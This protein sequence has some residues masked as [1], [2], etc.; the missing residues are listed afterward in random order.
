[1][2]THWLS[3][4][5]LGALSPGHTLALLAVLV[6]ANGCT[7]KNDNASPAAGAS[8]GGAS[9]AGSTAMGGASGGT[10][11]SGGTT[12]GT[13]TAG[14][15][16]AGGSTSTAGNQGSGGSSVSG[17]L[18]GGFVVGL[19]PAA[20]GAPAYTSV[21]GRFYDGPT[22]ATI[23]LKEAR[24]QGN[25]KLLVPFVPFCEPM[26]DTSSA[27]CTADNV[28]TPKPKPIAVG[29]VQLSGLGS[30]PLTLKPGGASAYQPSSS[31]PNPP[32]QPGAEVNLAWNG[33][34]M[35]TTCI[36]ALEVTTPSPIP[37]KT[38]SSVKLAWTPPATNANTRVRIAMDLAHHG[39]KKG[40]IQCEVDDTGSFEIPEP[41]ITDLVQLGLAGFPTISLDRVSVGKVEALPNVTL[42]MSSVVTLPVDTGVVSCVSDT[43]CNGKTC[44]VDRACH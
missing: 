33:P 26:C 34:A 5:S 32:C 38:G 6:F 13:T 43:E 9:M 16:P 23:P 19:E 11:G 8:S 14:T 10:T 15:N 44:G 20:D 2:R 18:Y 29:E 1:M 3:S 24:A 35:R 21:L 42:V 37:V 7:S 36:A 22:P 28:C 41:L 4:N 12:A 39:G 40:E 31:L 17:P 30:A 27:V 25:C